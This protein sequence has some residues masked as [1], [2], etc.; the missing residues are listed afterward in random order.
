MQK[1]KVSPE[2]EHLLAAYPWTISGR[3]YVQS[4]RR[5]VATLL[6]RLI[7]SAPPG[8]VV[9]HINGDP[10]DN[11]RENLRIC[12]HTENMRNRK[13]SKSNKLGLKGVHWDRGRSRYR[14]LI[15]V[16]GK[17][18]WLG[19]YKTAEEAKAAY[20]SAAP[21]YHGEFARLA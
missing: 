10:S 13:V 2:D 21:I 20:D 17:K 14:A 19:S 5:G 11:R 6:H 3:G 18:K 16:D 9:D 8:S 12:S 1:V 15:W 7:L 4:V